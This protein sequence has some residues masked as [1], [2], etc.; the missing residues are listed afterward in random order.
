[1]QS[2]D[3]LAPVFQV[4]KALETEKFN[5]T[6]CHEYVQV[7][8]GILAG[9]ESAGK[10]ILYLSDLRVCAEAPVAFAAVIHDLAAHSEPRECLSAVMECALSGVCINN[11]GC[12]D[13]DV[14]PGRWFSKW[15]SL[16]HGIVWYTVPLASVASQEASRRSIRFLFAIAA[17]IRKFVPC[18]KLTAASGVLVLMF[19]LESREGQQIL[20]KNKSDVMDCHCILCEEMA[21]AVMSEECGDVDAYFTYPFAYFLGSVRLQSFVSA[22]LQANTRVDLPHT[23]ELQGEATKAKKRAEEFVFDLSDAESTPPARGTST[24]K[25]KLPK[26]AAA[27]PSIRLSPSIAGVK[28]ASSSLDIYKNAK[29]ACVPDHS[30]LVAAKKKIDTAKTTIDGLSHGLQLSHL[31]ACRKIER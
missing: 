28:R 12:A 11:W 31:F 2:A 1:M 23:R 8:N 14:I 30:I 22:V 29:C 24:G 25:G 15:E 19:C 16:L 3:L 5:R 27:I 4:H 10:I 7:A 17:G 6:R 9:G 26:A 21:R 20:V 13:S 18:R